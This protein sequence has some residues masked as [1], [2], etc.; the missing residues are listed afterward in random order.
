M[1]IMKQWYAISHEEILE[2]TGISK[3]NGLGENDIAEKKSKHGTNE[4]IEKKKISP[5]KLLWD[6][7]KETMVLILIGAAV[8][9]GILGQE[10]EALAIFAIVIL[11]AILGFIQ[12]YRAEKAI[13]EL[14]KLSVPNV[15]VKR[16]GALK[17]LSARE[18]VPGDIIHLEAGNL[19]PADARLLEVADL[20]V[21]E[22]ALTGE[23]LS[24]EKSTNK[25]DEK[26]DL[27]ERVNMVYMGTT[28]T[29]G[30]ATAI[31]ARIGMETE[32]GKIADSL[33]DVESEKTPLQNKLN[34]LGKNLAIAGTI[35]AAIIGIVGLTLGK[36]FQEMFL[37]AI[38]IAVAVVPEGLPAVVTITLA[39]GSRKLL[40]NKALIR[41][42][43]AV[44]TLG[45]VTVIC[46]DKTGTLTQ[47]KMSVSHIGTIEKFYKFPD[48]VKENTS[49]S[50]KLALLI[51]CLC[52][53]SEIE[54][55]QGEKSIL[56]EPTET[57]IINGALSLGLP[58]KEIKKEIPRCSEIPFDSD[59]RLMSTLHKISETN[60]QDHISVLKIIEE[61]Y[62]VF[63]KGATDSV[64]ERCNKVF[65]TDGIVE[66]SQEQKEKI[67]D[68]NDKLAEKGTRVLCFSFKGISEIPGDKHSME[69]DQIFAGITG[70][71]DP[72]REEVLEA[73]NICREAGI[74]PIMITGDHPLTAMAIAQ[75]V[76]FS[77]GKS[78]I[79]G[80]QLDELDQEQ[81]ANEVFSCS[82]FARVAPENKLKIVKAF[83]SKGEIVAMTGDGVNDAPSLKK[84][85]I[86][87]AMG[88]TGTDVSK[89]AA[90][91]VLLDD[92]FTTIVTS[93]KEGRVIFDNL[94]RFV[95][96]SLSG[97]LGKVL[98]MLVA[99]LF[100]IVVALSPLQLL[101]LNLLTDGLLGLG[102]GME[103]AEENVMKRPP[104]KPDAPILDKP[105]LLHIGWIG[106][107]I[108]IVCLAVAWYFYAEENS[109]WQTILFLTIG[110]AQVGQALGLRSSSIKFY[111]VT[112]NLLFSIMIVLVIVLQCCLILIPFVGKFFL[113]KPLSILEFGICAGLG[114]LVFVLV[115]TEKI[116]TS[117][118]KLGLW[119]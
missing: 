52:N 35:A 28:I 97:N 27:A 104:R 73:V 29:S 113:L 5:L 117:K 40:Q 30:R 103:P 21:Q 1:F 91:M 55:E 68:Y 70:L 85:D 24:V 98:I 32:L 3:E 43:P 111:S 4:L 82:V 92:N 105:T 108:A 47:N 101:W 110:F 13:S 119:K 50:V 31:V 63:T 11:F 80:R 88:I 90:D 18:L 74:R 49:E 2:K 114:L 33:Q 69:D 78:S 44:E 9:S 16:E 94:L 58:I 20:K 102:L 77:E 7:F 45:S 72:P 10:T 48:E 53:D 36:S 75:K 57:A 65:T 76:N 39:L 107:L 84:A 87:I 41:R 86:G 54:E 14:K 15:K 93:V 34:Q 46:S 17:E 22:A 89:E 112:S 6:Q 37:V 64:L 100:G 12:E 106:V 61:K 56:G 96:F 118:N 8:I 66:F 42:L 95:K 60:K 71:W 19:V 62:V 83:Q 79:T 23:S 51:G 81:L 59:R 25:L 99:P 67:R 115:R 116:L 26:T 38:S 109:N